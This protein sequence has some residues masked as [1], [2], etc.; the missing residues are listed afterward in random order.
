MGEQLV[1]CSD[2]YKFFNN[3]VFYVAGNTKIVKTKSMDHLRTSFI[4]SDS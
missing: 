4:M 2:Q 1:V 3:Y